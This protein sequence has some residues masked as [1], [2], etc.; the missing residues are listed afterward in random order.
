[1]TTPGPRWEGPVSWPKR[2]RS[3]CWAR[4]KRQTSWETKWRLWPTTASNTPAISRG[5]RKT[6]TKP[7]TDSH[8]W[9]S[10]MPPT[11]AR[12]LLQHRPTRLPSH[13]HVTKNRIKAMISIK[14]TW[15]GMEPWRLSTLTK[16]VE[17][18][19]KEDSLKFDLYENSNLISFIQIS[20]AILV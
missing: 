7:G 8:R 4:C 1:M 5:T 12:R 17:F 20:I 6:S 16:E 3:S 9:T 13:F 18:S 10:S 19:K 15:I 11:L 14:K 2:T